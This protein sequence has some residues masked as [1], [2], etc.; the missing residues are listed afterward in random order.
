MTVGVI[1]AKGRH[2]DKD[3]RLS[4]QDYLQTDASI[5]PGNSGGPLVNLD[6]KVVGI[7]TAI[8]SPSRFNVGIGF[9]VPSNTIREYLPLLMSGKSVQRGFLGIQYTALEAEVAREFGVAGGMQIG[10]LAR[11]GDQFIGPA[12]EAGLQE[13]DII[14]AVNGQEMVTNHEFRR[15]VAGSAPGT[16]LKF[17]VVRPGGGDK[18]TRIVTIK[19][20]DWNAQNAVK[21]LLDSVPLPAVPASRLGLKIEDAEKL[22][23][24][25]RDLL[26]LEKDAKGAVITD[27]EPGSPAD[28]ADLRRGLRIARMRTHGGVWQTVAGEKEF[29][30]MEEAL[31]PGARVLMQ[32]RDGQDVSLYKL[33]ILPAKK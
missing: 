10:S 8:L 20:G 6:G 21:P 4:L 22:S 33:L 13:G 30:R 32:V 5:N 11:R 17:A 7:N 2:L 23:A 18:E 24:D 16:I 25:E 31:L 28:D 9:A 27:V 14:T 26:G 12:Q 1:S 19:L 15:I 3:N 29:A